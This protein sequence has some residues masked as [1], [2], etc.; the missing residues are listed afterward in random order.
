MKLKSIA[1]KVLTDVHFHVNEEI[2]SEVTRIRVRLSV[3]VELLE[4]V[5]FLVYRQVASKI[6]ETLYET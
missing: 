5:S 6:E 4:P 1:Y 2:V 3:E